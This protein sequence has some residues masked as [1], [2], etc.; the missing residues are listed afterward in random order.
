MIKKIIKK[1]IFEKAAFKISAIYAIFSILWIVFS[2]QF[3]FYFV[4]DPTLITEIQSIKG[5]TFVLVTACLIYFLLLREILKY[6]KAQS[7]LEKKELLYR[8]VAGQSGQL[9]YDYC[10]LTGKIDWY[11]D[12][13]NTTGYSEDE[14]QE[15][16]INKWEKHLH[17]DDLNK[18]LELLNNCIKNG[19]SF[20]ADYRFKIKNGEYLHFEDNGVF[21]E[22]EKKEKRILGIMK[23]I[24]DKVNYQQVLVQSEKMMSVGKLAAGMAHEL[25]NPLGVII[26]G[27]QTILRRTALDSEKNQKISEKINFSLEKMINYFKEQEIDQ[28]LNG[29]NEAGE[30]AARIIS[31]MLSFSHGS[32]VHKT[33]ESLQVLIEKSLSLASQDYDLRQKYNLSNIKII[34]KYDSSD[35]MIICNA[36]ELE[37]V[38]LNLLKNSAYA[39]YEYSRSYNEG[40]STIDKREPIIKIST[41]TDENYV[42]IEIEDNGIGMEEQTSN[43][44]F[45][46]FFTTQKIGKGIGLGLSA[47]YFI[48]TNNHNGQIWVESKKNIGTKLIIKIP[49]E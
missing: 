15:I 39:I 46:P 1:Y 45:E 4:K 20:S 12:I 26:Q 10:V 28:F 30:R 19:G 17:T 40:D 36:V 21:T 6:K 49:K 2:D 5:W 22:S 14:M 31:N 35:P 23:N 41:Y 47:S 11:G 32:S 16:D 8:I 43:R 37:R 38:I 24:T 18:T 9:V 13:K 3:V 7:I 48:I 33:S 29:I 34:K 27:V 44:I 25:N 42:S